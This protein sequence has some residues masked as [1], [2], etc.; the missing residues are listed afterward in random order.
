MSISS[1]SKPR[2]FGSDIRRLL[3]AAEAGQK[4]DILA[5]SSGHLGPSSLNH[6]RPPREKEQCFWR[7]SQRQPKTSNPLTLQQRQAKEL[8]YVKKKEI[9][10]GSAEFTAGFPSAQPEASGS[11]QD[12]T[13]DCSIQAVRGE[14][15]CLNKKDFGSLKSV[16]VKSNALAPEKLHNSSSGPC[17]NHSDKAPIKEDQMKIKQHPVKQDFWGGINAAELHERKL[18]RELK[19]LSTQSWPSRDRLAVFSD[20]FDDVCEGSAV[21]GRILREIKT[22][23]DLYVNHVMS[24]QSTLH[25]PLPHASHENPGSETLRSVDLEEKEKEVHWL[26]QEARKTLEENQQLR[27]VL[28]NVLAVLRPEDKDVKNASLS[29]SGTTTGGDNS[30]QSKRLQ[31]LN[32]WVEIQQLEEMIQEKLVPAATATATERRI[33]SLKTE[34]MRLIASNH[35]LK[36]TNKDLENQINTV[37]KREKVSKVMRRI[38]WDEILSDL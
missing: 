32:M 24:S 17:R 18:E 15:S 35:C 25:N 34:I 11:R 2:C 9:K 31:V 14:D 20:V 38:L 3:L 23:Y 5:Y 10:D 8:A 12:H 6:S 36:T 27:D 22:E 16:P 28:Q 29:D 30:I 26:E 37:L 13:T 7:T 1:K 21:F 4:A 19:K 33:R